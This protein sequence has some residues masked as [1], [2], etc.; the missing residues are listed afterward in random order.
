MFH[1]L[2]AT[3]LYAVPPLVLFLASHPGVLPKYLQSLRHVVCGAAPLG[4]LD[5]ERFLKRAPPNTEI[6]QG[7]MRT[8]LY[9]TNIFIWFLSALVLLTWPS[10]SPQA[11]PLLTKFVR[12]IK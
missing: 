3:V 4:G 1:F 7:S 10:G 12:Q 9:L 11:Q 2:Q 8:L 5:V 6:V